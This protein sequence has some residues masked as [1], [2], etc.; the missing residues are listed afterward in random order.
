MIG[1]LRG[2]TCRAVY[3]AFRETLARAKLGSDSLA[4]L[5]CACLGL[6]AQAYR[7]TAAAVGLLRMAAQLEQELNGNAVEPDR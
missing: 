2:K 7:R 4:A 3:Q 6:P 5:R 1:S